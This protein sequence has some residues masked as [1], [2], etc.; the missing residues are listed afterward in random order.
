MIKPEE[1]R[2]GSLVYDANDLIKLPRQVIKISTSSATIMRVRNGIAYNISY[3][4]LLP[5][6]INTNIMSKL[7][8][9]I[10]ELRKNSVQI[11]R[12]YSLGNEYLFIEYDNGEFDYNYLDSKTELKYIHQIQNSTYVLTGKQITLK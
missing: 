5:I 10:R 4:K 6:K 1:L 3:D 2:I 11:V 8:F 7:G 12:S 9:G